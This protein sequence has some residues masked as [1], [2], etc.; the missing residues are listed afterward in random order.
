MQFLVYKVNYNERNV[1]KWK[2]NQSTTN[3]GCL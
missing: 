2:E 3:W 1:E